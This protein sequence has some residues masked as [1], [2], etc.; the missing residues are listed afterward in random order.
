MKSTIPV[1]F[2]GFLCIASVSQAAPQLS[3]PLTGGFFDS[4]YSAG[5]GTNT[6]YFV[7]DFGG[8]GGGKHG[9]V[10]HWNGT[11][12]ADNAVQAIDAA[13][14]LDASYDNFGSPEQPNLFINRLADPPDVDM[15]DFGT[16]GRFWDY[17]LGTYSGGTVNWNESPYGISGRDFST[18]DVVQTLVN[19]GFYGFYAS[20]N[21][22]PPGLPVT[23]LHG[24]D[25]NLDGHVNAADIKAIEAALADLNAYQHGANSQNATLQAGDLAILG[26]LNGDTK[27]NGAD[28]QKLLNLLKSGG[29][30]KSVV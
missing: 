2:C 9:F 15:P 29:D 25:F 3:V 10:Y 20:A 4:E 22:T 26:D 7:A 23:T 28:L 21:T 18:G 13:G 24:G 1:L 12:T 27:I 14:S 11:Q 5:S 8:S 6:A 30:R 16:D 17:F 19:G